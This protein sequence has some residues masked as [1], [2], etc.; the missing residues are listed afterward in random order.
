MPILI[1]FCVVSEVISALM[2]V[3][4]VAITQTF[5]SAIVIIAKSSYRC[6]GF[7]MA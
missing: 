1:E 7:R 3:G 4:G 2:Y 5:H 6:L